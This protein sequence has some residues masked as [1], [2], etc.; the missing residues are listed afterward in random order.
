MK[1]RRMRM[2]FNKWLKMLLSVIKQENMEAS[3]YFKFKG[4]IKIFKSKE[5]KTCKL[6]YKKTYGMYLI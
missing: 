5:N 6:D 3:S 1:E 4:H 2:K